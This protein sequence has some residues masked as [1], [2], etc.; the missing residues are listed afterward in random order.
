VLIGAR[1]V[2]EARVRGEDDERVFGRE[3]RHRGDRA[4]AVEA[5][6]I[7]GGQR[8]ARHRR[9]AEAAAG[10]SDERAFERERG[11]A[12]AERGRFVGRRDARRKLR[13]AVLPE[14]ERK[15]RA[16]CDL[17]GDADGAADVHSDEVLDRAKRDVAGARVEDGDRVEAVVGERADVPVASRGAHRRLGDE[18]RARIERRPPRARV[19]RR[20][21]LSVGATSD[22]K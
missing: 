22:T 10:I 7:A 11:V 3:L 12:D 2:T 15:R 18:V 9:E 5:R 13:V 8:H 21:R 20:K 19:D 6:A 4:V 1:F 14:D 17:V 16:D